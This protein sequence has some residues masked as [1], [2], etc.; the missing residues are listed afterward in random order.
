MPRRTLTFQDHGMP[1]GAQGEVAMLNFQQLPRNW[2]L[3]TLDLRETLARF[4]RSSHFSAS[5]GIIHLGDVDF[6]QFTPKL[7]ENCSLV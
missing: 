2:P 3:F 7:C 6:A 5:R 4:R 1:G